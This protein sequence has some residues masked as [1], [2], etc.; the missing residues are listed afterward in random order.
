MNSIRWAARILGVLL[1][2]LFFVFAVG[3]GIN[4]LAMR[5]TEIVQ[6]SVLLAALTGMLVVWRQELLGGAVVLAGM[7]AFYVVNFAVSGHWPGG[8]VFPLCFVPGI[9]ALISWASERAGT[10]QSHRLPSK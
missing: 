3:Q 7:L 6:M 1:V 10:L 9:L 2:G 4:P 5:G 8:W